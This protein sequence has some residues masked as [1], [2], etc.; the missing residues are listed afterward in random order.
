VDIRDVLLPAR[1]R[2]PIP[3]RGF[4]RRHAKC[5]SDVLPR[6]ASLPRGLDDVPAANQKLDELNVG[7]ERPLRVPETMHTAPDLL[8]RRRPATGMIRRWHSA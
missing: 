2:A 3:V 4:V 7:R 8:L 1:D 5:G 6:R